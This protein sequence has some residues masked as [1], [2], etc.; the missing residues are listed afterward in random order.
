V[1]LRFG[2]EAFSVTGSLAK[3]TLD[4]N[5]LSLVADGAWHEAAIDVRQIREAFPDVTHLA[6]VFFTGPKGQGPGN[7]YAFRSFCVSATR[8]CPAPQ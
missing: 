4:V 7:G 5:T 8:T 6:G 1:S 2:L 3:R